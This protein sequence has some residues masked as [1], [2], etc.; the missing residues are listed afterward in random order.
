MPLFDCRFCDSYKD[1]LQ[2][3]QQTE[4]IQ[5]DGASLLAE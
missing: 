5:I 4:L 1:R 3:V 2:F